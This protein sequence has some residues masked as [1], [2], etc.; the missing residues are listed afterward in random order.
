MCFLRFL[1]AKLPS[2]PAWNMTSHIDKL[3]TIYIYRW[4]WCQKHVWIVPQWS[5]DVWNKWFTFWWGLI[6]S[7]CKGLLKWP[8]VST[9]CHLL[10]MD[11]GYH[12]PWRSGLPRLS[13]KTN[14]KIDKK[15][16]SFG[17]NTAHFKGTSGGA[18]YRYWMV[19]IHSHLNVKGMLK[20]K[21]PRSSQ[22][23]NNARCLKTIP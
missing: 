22:V 13:N 17:G 15:N 18:R 21:D 19:L 20:H 2:W 7:Y 23:S 5:G 4:F 3:M 16:L 1:E 12:I 10:D 6:R 14:H 8:G 9:T 11:Q